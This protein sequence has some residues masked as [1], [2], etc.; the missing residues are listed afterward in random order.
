MVDEVKSMLDD[1]VS[2]EFLVKLGLEYKY[3]TWYLTGKIGY[4]QMVEELGNAIK[5]FAKR[6][7]TWFRRD[8]RIIWLDMNED[9]VS[10]ASAL[11]TDFLGREA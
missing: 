7:M 11:I 10:R 2:E 1:G 5:R 4:E 6:Q 3:L 9:P 8:P